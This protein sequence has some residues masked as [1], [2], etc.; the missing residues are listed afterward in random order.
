MDFGV[1]GVIIGFLVLGAL[2]ARMQSIFERSETA[3]G[4]YVTQYTAMWVSFLIIGSLE[5]VS[6]IF[7]FFFWPIYVLVGFEI[8]R[9]RP[10]NGLGSDAS[11]G[12][13]TA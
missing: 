10:I 3:L 6:Q 12:G 2:I 13:R 4:L 7:V 11:L 5:V 8:L 1:P 9:R